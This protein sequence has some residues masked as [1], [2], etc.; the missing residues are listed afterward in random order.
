MNSQVTPARITDGLSKTALI[1]ESVLGQPRQGTHH[2]PQT[3][4]KFAFG[5]PLSDTVCAG[6]NQWNMSDPRGFAWVNGEFRCA[7]YNHYYLPNSET[8]DCMGVQLGGGV[9]L[10]FTPYGWRT[11][12]SNH[13]GGVNVAMADGS[14]QF[15][16][17]S[18][19][20]QIWKAMATV[21]GDEAAGP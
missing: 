11:A 9:Q 14:L 7:L 16:D 18:I 15:I 12:R 5:A 10:Q 21:A 4:Y 6:A 19:D 3:E 8:P 17:N 1:A 13:P 20:P 2:D